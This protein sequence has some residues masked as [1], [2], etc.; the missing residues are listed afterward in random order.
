MAIRAGIQVKY[1]PVKSVLPEQFQENFPG[2]QTDA[3]KRGIFNNIVVEPNSAQ[4]NMIVM[5]GWIVLTGAGVFSIDGK[6]RLGI[7]FINRSDGKVSDY[8]P[9]FDKEGFP[10]VQNVIYDGSRFLYVAGAFTIVDGVTT[11]N[12]KPIEGI[13]RM[14]MQNDGKLDDTWNPEPNPGNKIVYGFN[15]DKKTVYF[16]SATLTTVGVTARLVVAEVS[17]EDSGSV[18]TWDPSPDGS[19]GDLKYDQPTQQVYLGGSFANIGGGAH[20][21]LVRMTSTGVGVVDGTW[22]P[23][24]DGSVNVILVDGL[25]TYV[26][27]FFQNIGG[28]AR[29][30]VGQIDNVGVATAWDPNPV[31]TAGGGLVFDL[32]KFEDRTLTGPNGFKEVILIAG[33]FDTVKGSGRIGIA[34][35]DPISDALDAWDPLFVA[36]TTTV[37]SIQGREKTIYLGG[38]FVNPVG[39]QTFVDAFQFP[40]W[41]DANSKYFSKAGDDTGAGTRAD[42]LLTIKK[43]I[44]G[45]AGA[46]D[47]GVCLDS[48]VYEERI[49]SPDRIPP[50]RTLIAEPGNAPTITLRQGAKFGTYG[51]RVSGRT[52]FSTGAFPATFVFVSKLGNDGTGTRGDQSLPFL[53]VTAAIVAA[54]D[55]DTVQIDDSELYITGNMVISGFTGLTIQAKADETPVF[56]E[57]DA[58]P[59]G[60]IHIDSQG[61]GQTLNVFGI[62]FL[63]VPDDEFPTMIALKGAGPL[64]IA[65]CTFLDGANA[66]VANEDLLM[67][68]SLFSENPRQSVVMTLTG[69]ITN[70][71]FKNCG[72]D[73]TAPTPHSIQSGI[74][75]SDF[76]MDHCSFENPGFF[77]GQA[78]HAIRIQRNAG[79]PV[80]TDVISFCDFFNNTGR[81]INVVGVEIERLGAATGMTTSVED[82]KFSDLGRQ[83][84]FFNTAFNGGWL[85]RARRCVGI[86]CQA[87]N[88]GQEGTYDFD[89]PN[90]AIFE[91]LV[92]I[93]SGG[94][95]FFF[96]KE[97]ATPT[98]TNVLNCV[99]LNSKGSG[100]KVDYFSDNS[101]TSIWRGLVESGSGADGLTMANPLSVTERVI[102]CNFDVAISTSSVVLVITGTIQ[103]SD[104][105]FV[106]KVAGSEN[107]SYF[108]SSPAILAVAEDASRN[109]GFKGAII[110]MENDGSS[111][112]GF[113]VEGP[114]NFYNGITT[115]IRGSAPGSIRD[116]TFNKLGIYAVLAGSGWIIDGCLLQNDGIGIEILDNNATVERTVGFGCSSAF[117]IAKGK[118]L[119]IQNDTAYLCDFGQFDLQ[120]A[121]FL[122]FKNNVYSGN[123]Q[124]D[125]S[126]DASMSNSDVELLQGAATI[127]N[128]T[129]LNPLF[130]DTADPDL[131]L[132][133]KGSGFFFDSPAK[134]LGDDGKDAGAFEV[135]NG[136]VLKTFTLVDF[137]KV[138]SATKVYRN[139]N[140]YTRK[141]NVIKLREGE[142]HGGVS[143]SDA[144]AF[145]REHV[146]TWE[147]NVDMPDEQVT[148]LEAIFT[149]G[150]GECQISFDGGLTFQPVRVVRSS[151]FEF[152]ELAE[153]AYSTDEIPTPIRELTFRESE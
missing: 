120:N 24:P 93:A 19:V 111:I 44:Q 113:I 86:R 34:A 119:T 28:S 49:E 72:G 124:A 37:R 151:G 64:D 126:G 108:A 82:C 97:G 115:K 71:Y 63:D 83:A 27:G 84:I 137:E 123:G 150:D 51:A 147:P 31:R 138:L 60:G 114:S 2:A 91:D 107:V 1:N 149:T 105:Q 18:T 16:G 4:D 20:T 14:D 142:T 29:N 153:L 81:S 96:D 40:I 21:R 13:V 94:N 100:F 127:V 92:S 39:G 26:G 134:A 43:T 152:T 7:G 141:S 68:S 129:R 122:A 87:Q 95:G 48:G 65:D 140:F 3:T 85:L 32:A 55:N 45:M 75:S 121:S 42:P 133:T 17:T 132:Q 76:K 23:A 73:Q 15:P 11:A 9:V 89:K 22:S 148:D 38:N 136:F 112:Q 77:R 33:V 102:Y 67:D 128:G 12:S 78:W 135:S 61:A 47:Y 46:F 109:M 58:A 88:V 41:T 143:Y 70:C 52:R 6:T 5:D 146:L 104:P 106:S 99:A 139:P 90:V 54:L 30:L 110:D 130:R 62:T 53:T 10:V 69:A 131:R 56:F 8:A 59:G 98:G 50:D 117:I 36:P 74:G 144:S 103:N 125:Y 101:A 57:Q 35:V 116:C 79:S 145:K 66:I 25:T 118:H 80:G